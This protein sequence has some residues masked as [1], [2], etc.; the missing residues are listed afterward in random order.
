M[1]QIQDLGCLHMII[2]RGL[3]SNHCHLSHFFLAV[4]EVLLV[5]APVHN[6]KTNSNISNTHHL[7]FHLSEISLINCKISYED[8]II[9][10]T[11][12]QPFQLKIDCTKKN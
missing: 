11:R 3:F 1:I 12:K 10:A 4:C 9:W 7:P 2:A 8:N 5:P 6:S